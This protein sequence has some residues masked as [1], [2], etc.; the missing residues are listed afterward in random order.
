M[1]HD[2][3]VRE[4]PPRISLPKTSLYEHFLDLMD[5]LIIIVVAFGSIGFIFGSWATS[6]VVCIKQGEWLLLI[7]DAIA[8]PVGVVHGVGVWFGAW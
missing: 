1:R 7:A 6:V 8:F 5:S 4:R 3:K 2:S